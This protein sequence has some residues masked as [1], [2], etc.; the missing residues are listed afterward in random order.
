MPTHEQYVLR[1]HEKMLNLKC[2]W[3]PIKMQ[4]INLGRLAFRPISPLLGARKKKFRDV[5]VS[6]NVCALHIRVRIYIY[7]K[8][9]TIVVDQIKDLLGSAPSIVSRFTS[10]FRNSRS[11]SMFAYYSIFLNSRIT[12]AHNYWKK[13]AWKKTHY[14]V[15]TALSFSFITSHL[16]FFL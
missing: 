14:F 6:R 9:H 4:S 8:D 11:R 3:E 15:F 2:R 10:S 16:I 1:P 12:G 7:T 13:Y 5:F